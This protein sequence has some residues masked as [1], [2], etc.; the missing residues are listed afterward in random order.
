MRVANSIASGGIA[1][2]SVV[3]AGGALLLAILIQT[4]LFIPVVDQLLIIQLHR[5]MRIFKIRAPE[6]M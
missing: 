3:G 5:Q 6:Y 4:K 2:P 1:A